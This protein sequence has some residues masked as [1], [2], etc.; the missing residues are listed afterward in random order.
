LRTDWWPIPRSFYTGFIGGHIDSLLRRRRYLDQQQKLNQDERK[1]MEIIKSL[2]WVLKHQHL[3]G[4]KLDKF[5]NTILIIGYCQANLLQKALRFYYWFIHSGNI[6]TV[7]MLDCLVDATCRLAPTRNLKTHQFGLQT[8]P[9]QVVNLILKH[10]EKYQLIPSFHSYI[11]LI[12][13]LS[14]FD[15]PRAMTIWEEASKRYN[16][17]KQTLVLS[18]V[19]EYF[20]SPSKTLPT[21]LLKHLDRW[22]QWDQLVDATNGIEHSLFSKYTS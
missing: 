8:K 3:M 21:I 11:M 14:T 20:F 19:K 12:R 10:Y 17:R 2:R 5:Q 18:K 6:P 9:E 15:I 22:Q 4:Y 13:F 7:V 16:S 1:S